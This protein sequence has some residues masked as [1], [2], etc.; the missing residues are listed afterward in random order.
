MVNPDANDFRCGVVAIIGRPNVG[1]STLLNELI[2]TK[3]AIVSEIPQ[4]TRNQIRGIHN[5]ARGQIIFID[6]PGV[7]KSRDNLD[8]VMNR[9]ATGNLDDVDCLIYLVDSDDP[10]GP[11]EEGLASQIAA[12]K[13]PVILGLNKV[14]LN[15]R[16]IPEYLALWERL[17]GKPV[18]EMKNF[19]LIALSGKKGTNVEDLKTMIF[20]YLP[21]GPALYPL[22]VV[23]DVPQRMVIADI[24]REK[25]FGLM[26]EEVPHSLAVVIEEL[27]PKGKVL[28][29]KALVLIER[30]SQKMIVVGKGG[31]VL[32]KAGTAARQE[33]EQLL[34]SKVFLELYVKESRHWRD[35]PGYLQEMG[36]TS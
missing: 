4:T 29:I 17:K 8:R 13:V 20:S 2:G 32:K 24:I 36:Y 9:A 28:H 10:P 23:S 16:C 30:S 5:D 19:S 12:A 35:D 18:Q 7:H 15:G 26:R 22:D 21:P 3:V 31:T 11:E 6:T 25:L 34:K 1:K 27:Q 14:D 33:L